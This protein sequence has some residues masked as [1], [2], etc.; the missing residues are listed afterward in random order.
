VLGSPAD[1]YERLRPCWEQAGGNFLIFCTH[2]SG[3]LVGH[4]LPSMRL[5]S[6]ELLPALRQVSTAWTAEHRNSPDCL[7][8]LN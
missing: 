7:C 5:I 6:D 3:I 8:P 2:W 1:C 4:A